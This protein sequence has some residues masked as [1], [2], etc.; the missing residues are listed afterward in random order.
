MRTS[1]VYDD[2]KTN[3]KFEVEIDKTYNK[4]K[5]LT[6][7]LKILQ[8]KLENLKQILKLSNFMTEFRFI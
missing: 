6:S 5:N 4:L 3:E 8:S 1:D 2:K 7:K